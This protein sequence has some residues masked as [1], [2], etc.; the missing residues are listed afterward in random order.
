MLNT[1]E[2]LVVVEHEVLVL[3]LKQA[4]PHIIRVVCPKQ[5]LILILASILIH[6]W[7]ILC[8]LSGDD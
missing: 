4:F 3:L 5:L 1:I 7:H 6:D 8:L 2:P